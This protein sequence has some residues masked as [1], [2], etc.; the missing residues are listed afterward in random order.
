MYIHTCA[1]LNRWNHEYS[2][3]DL[4]EWADWHEVAD[5]SIPSE[6]VHF[7]N[8]R[9]PVHTMCV[10]AIFSSFPAASMYALYATFSVEGAPKWQLPAWRMERNEATCMEECEQGQH[11]GRSS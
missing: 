5:I 10:C 8:Q 11:E 2:L 6:E 1:S 3:I 4:M 7:A 9:V